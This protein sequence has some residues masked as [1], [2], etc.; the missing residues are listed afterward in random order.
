MDTTN[1]QASTNLIHRPRRIVTDWRRFAC[2]L[3]R[4]PEGDISAAYC[5]DTFP[6][7]KIFTHEGRV[8][9]NCGNLF[10]G[11][12]QCAANCHP[13]FPIDEYHGPESVRY[14]YEGKEGQFKG[15]RFRLGPKI[16]FDS[17]NP[18]VD[19]WIRMF[20]VLY[21]DGGMFAH[22][23]TYLEFLQEHLAPK[24]ANEQLAHAQELSLCETSSMPGTQEEMKR[25]LDESGFDFVPEA[26]N[27]L[28]LS[29]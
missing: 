8:F 24:S 17:N 16:I 22:G 1:D 3:W 6:K 2:G 19:E 27:Q 13:L 21:A 4:L 5:A 9:T 26:Q 10:S 29:F 18:T 14:S 23:V 15:K 28:E 11:V 20:R 7:L 12:V 25:F